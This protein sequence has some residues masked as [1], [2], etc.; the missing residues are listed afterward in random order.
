MCGAH[1]IRRDYGISCRYIV[2]FY[3]VLLRNNIWHKDGKS[4][5]KKSKENKKDLVLNRRK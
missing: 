5:N 4:G 2:P 1:D 3:I